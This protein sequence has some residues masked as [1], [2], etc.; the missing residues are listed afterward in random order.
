MSRNEIIKRYFYVFSVIVLIILAVNAGFK[1]IASE[2]DKE[3][4]L[5]ISVTSDRKEYLVNEEI[6]VKYTVTPEPLKLNDINTMQKKEVVLIINSSINWLWDRTFSEQKDIAIDFINKFK[7][8]ENIRIS[9][10]N[11]TDRTKDIIQLK[12]VSVAAERNE[13]LNFISSIEPEKYSWIKGGPKSNTGDAIR[14]AMGVFSEGDTKKYVLVMSNLDPNYYTTYNNNP[15]MII[16][17]SE[18]QGL[19]YPNNDYNGLEYAKNMSSYM[20][21]R[22]IMSFFIGVKGTIGDLFHDNTVSMT[23]LANA[24][25][26]KNYNGNDR[27]SLNMIYNDISDQIKAAH[28][29]DNIKFKF[30]V[31]NNLN[32]VGD[33][34]GVTQNENQYSMEVNDIKYRLSDDKTQ[35]V[36]DPFDITLKFKASKS[37]NYTI[38]DGWNIS[39]KSLSGQTINQEVYDFDISVNSLEVGFNVDRYFPDTENGTQNQYHT[40]AGTPATIEY[41]I[42]PQPIKVSQ[43][44]G[45][46][47][48]K[49]GASLFLSNPIIVDN[50]PANVEFV[51]S[52]SNS[53]KINIT[54]EELQYKYNKQKGVLEAPDIIKTSQIKSNMKGSYK[55]ND[56]IFQYYDREEKLKQ[57]RFNEVLQLHVNK[58][59]DTS[60]LKNGVFDNSNRWGNYI[61][62][63]RTSINTIS[64]AENRLAAYCV[65]DNKSNDIEINLSEPYDKVESIDYTKIEVYEAKNGLNKVYDYVISDD[66]N[67]KLNIKIESKGNNKT[68]LIK[69]NFKVSLKDKN[70][71]C[72]VL[73]SVTLNNKYEDSFRINIVQMPD[74]F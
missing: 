43:E 59:S 20:K 11:Y 5:N 29:V 14:R 60:L 54:L 24:A 63:S 72:Q 45:E 17:N 22:E 19:K 47:I 69:Y 7:D 32:Y 42:S 61:D 50:M 8:R 40:T 49:S 53:K 18:K 44:L 37:G 41:K 70:K 12:N 62:I 68:Y 66:K 4:R 10:L 34:L 35:Y 67:G 57:E 46:R 25:G 71:E 52:G 21:D 48:E 6:N 58:A 36:A 74:L 30:S 51:D 23:S 31:P 39:Y 64:G 38:G 3:P 28:I 33:M 56:S 2:S 15:Y 73:S 65:L 16:E 55:L 9:V 26:G 1:V 13:L 27:N